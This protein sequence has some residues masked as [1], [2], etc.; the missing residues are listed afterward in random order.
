MARIARCDLLPHADRLRL[1]ARIREGVPWRALAA[2]F[3]IPQASIREWAERH[4]YGRNPTEAKRAA[5]DA[6]LADET[7]PQVAQQAEQTAQRAVST[8]DANLD[9]AAER[10]ARVAKS[11]AAICVATIAR[12]GQAVRDEM[13][14]R[15]LKVIAEAVAKAWETYSR[16]HKLDDAPQAPDYSA[17][18]EAAAARLR[19][20]LGLDRK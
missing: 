5:V 16:I 6:M 7:P 10:D 14:P 11:A 13:D 3:D 12:L 4:K 18:Y 17:E 9:S 19:A 15:T 8:G 1:I 20:R 2:E